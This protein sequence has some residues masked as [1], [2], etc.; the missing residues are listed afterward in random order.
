MN[1]VVARIFDPTYF[2]KMLVPGSMG[3]YGTTVDTELGQTMLTDAREQEQLL[4]AKVHVD[5]TRPGGND[6]DTYGPENTFRDGQD[7]SVDSMVDSAIPGLVPTPGGDK[8][9][10]HST[11]NPD[12]LTFDA[13][14]YFEEPSGGGQKTRASTKAAAASGLVNVMRSPLVKS[15]ALDG[16]IRVGVLG[17]L[18]DGSI[19]TLSQDPSGPDAVDDDDA[20][21]PLSFTDLRQVPGKKYRSVYFRPLNLNFNTSIAPEYN[22][23]SSFGRVDPVIGYQKTTRTYSLS[24][25]VHAFAPEDLE[26]MYNKMVWL[27]SM[28]YPSYGSDSLIRSGPVVRMRIGDVVSTSS[29]GVPGVIRNLGFDFTDALWELKRGM[30]VPRSFKVSLEFLALHDGP[31]GLLNGVF[32]VWQLPG[33]G[34]KDTNFASPTKTVTGPDGDGTLLTGQ[35]SKF[36]EPRK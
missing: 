11:T 22:E 6:S 29:G 27:S 7:F 2:L 26:V 13:S 21:V 9:L 20:R 25:E 10:K 23:G 18:A 1:P 5:P 17:E 4:L 33:G 34:S 36:G 24:F 31:V 19:N 32:G 30:K 3:H 28:C 15:N 35:F 14:K 8:F 12:L 16:V